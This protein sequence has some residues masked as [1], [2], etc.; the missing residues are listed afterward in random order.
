MPQARHIRLDKCSP[1]RQIPKDLFYL[2]KRARVCRRLSASI[3][4]GLANLVLDLIGPRHLVHGA[5][6][7]PA[8]RSYHERSPLNLARTRQLIPHRTQHKLGYLRRAVRAYPRHLIPQTR[9]P[10]SLD[11]SVLFRRYFR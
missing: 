10:E 6:I 4:Q 7:V 3:D 9:V 8:P 1:I 11:Q 5:L 2:N